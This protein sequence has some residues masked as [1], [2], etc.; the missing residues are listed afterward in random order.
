MQRF[1]GLAVAIVLGVMYASSAI[2]G[3][4][5][6]ALAELLQVDAREY[7]G[8][9]A[10]NG[11]WQVSAVFDDLATTNVAGPARLHDDNRGVYLLTQY[12]RVLSGEQEDAVWATQQPD[13]E[14]LIGEYMGAGVVYRS[15]SA[16]FG[17]AVGIA[18][19]GAPFERALAGDVADHEAVY[20]M[21]W[22]VE[23]SE[24]FT[25]QSDVQY[26]RN[27]GMDATIDANWTVGLR[28]ERKFARN[29]RLSLS[30]TRA[31]Q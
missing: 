24:G 8:V 20:E 6:N 16:E 1:F 17:I 29:P 13:S 22:R 9:R 10:G 11:F 21:S 3:D 23:L 18:E 12:P 4:V 15:A 5:A 28:F 27:P 7:S 26:I 14:N 25:L 31:M 2:A 19:L 30:R